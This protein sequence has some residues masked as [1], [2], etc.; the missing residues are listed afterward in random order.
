VNSRELIA[1]G[2][3]RLALA[4]V[5]SPRLDARLLFAFA[6][7]QARSERVSDGDPTAECCAL[8][9]RLLA[10]RVA[11]EP[12]AYIVGSKEFWSL[13]IEVGPGA[14][15]PRP[16]TE[17]L[18]EEFLRAFPDKN[19]SLDLVDLGTG[20]GC[21]LVAALHQRPS[22]RGLGVDVS[23]EA[24]GW[25]RRNIER[26]TLSAR[27]TLLKEDWSSVSPHG[28]D[29]VLSNPPYI[30]SADLLALEPEVARYEPRWALDGGADG[31]DAFRALAPRIAQ[32]MKPQGNAYVEIGAGQAADVTGIFSANGLQV[33]RI[34]L[35]LAGIER[36]LV[37]RHGGAGTSA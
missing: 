27:C 17:S 6:N 14:L 32:M 35:D 8:F 10:R 36:C 9:E 7:E 25:A 20:S 3:E 5:S 34:A 18:V 31:L 24:L 37:L 33:V 1:R 4:G 19:A 13:A 2:A 30:R 28:Y 15:V 23:E 29:A 16:E 12:L 21:L 11:R 22:A 26:H